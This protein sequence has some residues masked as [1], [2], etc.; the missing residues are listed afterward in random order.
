MVLETTA[1]PIGATGLR[2]LLCLFVI[3]MFFAELTIL[4]H[5]KLFSMQLLVLGLGI[6]P[7][8]TSCAC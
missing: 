6:V 5:F 2:L 8:F 4:I 7:S 3:S 1:L